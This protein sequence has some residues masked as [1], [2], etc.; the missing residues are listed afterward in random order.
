[1]YSELCNQ[2]VRTS[3]A[4][5][6]FLHDAAQ[7]FSG[8]VNH[9]YQLPKRN[10]HAREAEGKPNSRP[11]R[12]CSL[13]SSHCCNEE[14]HRGV[15]G[16]ASGSNKGRRRPPPSSAPKPQCGRSRKPRRTPE[17]PRTA[18]QSRHSA[19]L[20]DATRSRSRTSR[21]GAFQ[22]RSRTLRCDARRNPTTTRQF[23]SAKASS[24]RKSL[25]VDTAAAAS[26]VVFGRCVTA[27]TG[28]DR[29]LS[30]CRI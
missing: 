3:I 21:D 6:A 11:S 24:P 28:P 18:P 25:L 9:S 19:L 16:R 23:L 12:T 5:F 26:V 10:F 15:V 29:S 1:M 17:M 13:S 2:R 20:I 7:R 4:F 22:R 30:L 27:G 14:S 8:P